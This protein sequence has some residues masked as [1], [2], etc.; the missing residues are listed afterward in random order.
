MFEQRAKLL[1]S[2]EI[3]ILLSTFTHK[4]Y[5]LVL[6]NVEG[7]NPSMAPGYAPSISFLQYIS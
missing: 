5:I 2:D 4:F 3:Q 7:T 6:R 1:Y